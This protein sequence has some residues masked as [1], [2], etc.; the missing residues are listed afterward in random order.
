MAY[1]KTNWVDGETPINAENLNKM[2]EGIEEA[3]KTGGILNGTVVGYTG[4]TIPEGYEEIENPEIHRD[5]IALEEGYTLT[6]I[7]NINSVRK[8]GNVVELNLV[9]NA[10]NGF[11][12]TETIVARIGEGYRPM[13]DIRCIVGGGPSN[14]YGWSYTSVL[15]AFIRK[16]GYIAVR[17]STGS[18]VGYC[19]L[20]VTYLTD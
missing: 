3:G 4:D 1:E 5:K 8:S 16:D 10:T 15:L 18:S 19:L 2:E 20:H 9:I 7:N 11:T 12:S 17:N 6:N 13:A 14:N